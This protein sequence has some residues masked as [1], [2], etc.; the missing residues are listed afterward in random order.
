MRVNRAERRNHNRRSGYDRRSGEDRRK[1]DR[2]TPDRRQDERRKEIRREEDQLEEKLIVANNKITS[3]DSPGNTKTNIKLPDTT[4][5]GM[6]VNKI[7]VNYDKN[8]DETYID[9]EIYNTTEKR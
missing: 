6:H 7:N 2:G 8:G 5:K 4:Y 9:L 3:I 1:F